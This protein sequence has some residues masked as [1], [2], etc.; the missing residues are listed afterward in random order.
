MCLNVS[1]VKGYHVYQ[2]IW[3]LRIGE[4]LSTE[5]E[6]GNPKDKYTAYVKKNEWIIGHLPL[7][8]TG[9]FAKTIFYFLRVD[10]YSICEVEI[11]GKPVNLG[12]GEIMQVPCKLKLTG[13]SKFIN[14]LQ[15]SLKTKKLVTSY[16]RYFF[17]CVSLSSNLLHSKIA[18]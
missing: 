11:T 16:I 3:V 8:K 5:R 6:P 13:R 12:D 9:N 4:A 7:G 2:G 1:N 14:I 10:K 18:L 17:T 15:N